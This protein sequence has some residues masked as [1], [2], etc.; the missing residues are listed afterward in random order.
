MFLDSKEYSRR[1]LPNQPI[2]VYP[3]RAEEMNPRTKHDTPTP[4]FCPFNILSV[5][6]AAID[7]LHR[8]TNMIQKP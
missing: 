6:E 4:P 1:N 5:H 3:S 8:I 2:R 7:K